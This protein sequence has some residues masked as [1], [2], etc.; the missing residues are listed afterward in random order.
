MSG[1]ELAPVQMLAI[2]RQET[3]AEAVGQRRCGSSTYAVPAPQ[4]HPHPHEPLTAWTD[5]KV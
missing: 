3:D 5:P 2:E 4:H 1:A